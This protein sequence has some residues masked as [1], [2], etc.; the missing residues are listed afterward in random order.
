[1]AY[2]ASG[3]TVPLPARLAAYICRSASLIRS[4]ALAVLAGVNTATPMLAP[5]L[6]EGHDA[7]GAVHAEP[8]VCGGECAGDADLEERRCV[9]AR[10]AMSCAG[11]AEQ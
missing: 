11:N 5:P 3:Y 8:G 2:S 7:A 4:S 9:R 10:E 6:A 1:M